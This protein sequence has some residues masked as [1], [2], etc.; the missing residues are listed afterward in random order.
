MELEVAFTY[1][2][3]NVYYFAPNVCVLES[4]RQNRLRGVPNAYLLTKRCVDST[5]FAKV[6]CNNAI[7]IYKQQKHNMGAKNVA[8]IAI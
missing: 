2:K 6:S 5:D 3:T 1:S 8:R 4:R 7:F